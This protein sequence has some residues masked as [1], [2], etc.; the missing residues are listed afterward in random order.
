VVGV[1]AQQLLEN[2]DVRDA[3][4]QAA[5]ATRAAYR[6]ARGQDARQAVQDRKLR[7]RVAAAVAA[8]G[9]FA[10]AVSEVP[11]KPKPRWPRRIA[12]LAVIGAGAWLLSSPAVR[13][14]IEALLGRQR[15]EHPANPSTVDE[16]NPA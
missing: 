7:R 2:S 15:S 14:R 11:A 4:R 6:R 9:E 10:G 16:P 3:A 12:L 13:A 5:D 8:V 1:Y